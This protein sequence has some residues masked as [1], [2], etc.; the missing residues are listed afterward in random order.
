MTKNRS[1][2]SRWRRRP[3]GSPGAGRAFG[4]ASASPTATRSACAAP[5]AVGCWVAAARWAPARSRLVAAGVVPVRVGVGARAASTGLRFA[6]TLEPTW[7]VTPQLSL[8]VGIGFGGIVEGSTSRADPTPLPQHARHVVHLPGRAARRCRA[9]TAS[10]WRASRAPSGRSCSARARRRGFAVEFD[11]QWT[12]CVERHRRSSPTPPSPSCAASGGRTPAAR[13]R[14]GSRG[15]ERAL[16]AVLAA[17]RRRGAALA[18]RRLRCRLRRRGRAGGRGC[19]RR[20]GAARRR[21]RGAPAE[22]RAAA[23]ARTRPP[24]RIP[25]TRRRTPAPVVVTVK[26]LVGATARSTKVE[27]RHPRRSPS[28][29][30]RWSRAAQGLPV[31]AG[32]LRRQAG[33]GRD[34]LHAHL[35]AAAAAAAPRRVDA[36]PAAGRRRCAAGWS[37]W[38]RACRSPAPP[39]PPQIGDRHYSVDADSKG[40]FRLP[41]PAGRRA[42]DGARARATTPFLQQEHLAPQQE[43]AVTYYVERDRYDPYEIVIVGEQRREEVS[44]ITLRGAEIQQI[45]GTF[46]DPFRV[47][48]TLP[49]TASVVSLLPFPVIRGASPSSTGLPARR[50]AHPAALP[51]AGRARASIHPEFIDEIQFYPGGAPVLYGG[52][53]GGIIDGRTHRARQD[54]H[55]IDLDVN[56]LAG[57]RLRAR[58]DPQAR[59]HGHRGRR[60]TAIPASSCS[61]ATNQALAVLLG[62]PVPRSTAATPATAGRVFASAPR[63]S[64]TRVAATADRAPRTRRWRP[65]L[66]LDFHR[67]RP[68]R[69]PR[70]R[71]FDG[72]YRVVLGYDHTDSRRAPTSR[73]G[74]SS[75]RRAGPGARST[76]A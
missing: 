65:A 47:I 26:L 9:A 46:G 64:S 71:Q 49:G 4:W 76:R 66:I 17:A 18:Q 50:H 34:H 10:A 24:C 16:A 73:P 25:P 21:G 27:L 67:A 74:R 2:S 22:L 15:A 55:L 11:G 41:L 75:R 58:A 23:A 13:S 72:L 7:H 39:S 70:Q 37:R 56:L 48:Q 42:R 59:H 8:A 3:I 38:A 32:A 52:Y 1:Q 43:L 69:L 12:G 54:E 57:R 62:L 63:T 30:T 36:G 5:R 35:P 20:R 29:T 51:P 19:R 6:G 28:S 44:R 40:R 14:G 53:T 61:L 31:R 68:A 33:A 60:A 45:P